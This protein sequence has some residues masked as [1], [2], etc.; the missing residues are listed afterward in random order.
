MSYRTFVLNKL[1]RDKIVAA[2]E[3][4]GA[5]VEHK[6]LSGYELNK[7]LVDKLVE[8][9]KELQ[10][11]EVSANEL[12]D[13]QEIINQLCEN[14]GISKDE[15]ATTQKAKRDKNGGFKNGDYIGTLSLP[16]TS[17]WVEYYAQDPDR[18]P[19]MK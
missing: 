10:A 18:F 3:A 19:E 16:E 15:L 8:E 17:E 6:V 13:V 9:A 14:L 11:D 4:A 12:A 7:A 2:N 1:V 5:T